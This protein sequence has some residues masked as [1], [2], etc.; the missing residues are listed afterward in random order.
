LLRFG[1]LRSAVVEVVNNLLVK[2]K[3]PTKEMIQNLINI[4]LGFINTA[5]PDFVGANGAMTVI[6]DRMSKQ[7]QQ[8]QQQ[9]Q[10][11]VNARVTA[12]AVPPKSTMPGGYPSQNL[13]VNNNPAAST[14]G[15]EGSFLSAFFGRPPA[16]GATTPDYHAQQNQFQAN[17]NNNN[18]LLNSRMAPPT[19]PERPRS[20]SREAMQLQ[21]LEHVPD[22]IKPS[23][24]P[25]DKE[26]FETE[27]IKY[28]LTSYFDV[29]R[30]N[31]KDTVPKSI[32]HFLVNKSKE[33][34]QNELVSSLYRED[35]FEELLQESSLVQQRREQCKSMMDI[36]R[37]A[38]EILNE[39]REFQV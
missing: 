9:A 34:M 29:V 23:A 17:N 19:L 21:G 12:P 28:L 14:A 27:L 6:L 24:L 8:P 39:V 31:V 33:M 11:P 5:H 18:N 20:N 10:Q 30:K 15:P 32:M 38:H 25:N 35:L 26:T 3:T 16:G 2:Y 13:A 22:R 36:L 7:A 37:K 4:E 1:N